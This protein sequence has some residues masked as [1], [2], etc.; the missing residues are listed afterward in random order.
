MMQERSAYAGLLSRRDFFVATAVA[1][2]AGPAYAWSDAPLRMA[3]VGCGRHGSRCIEAMQR[4]AVRPWA[5]PVLACDPAPGARQHARRLG[6]PAVEQEAQAAWH[7]TDVDAVLIATPDAAH[8]DIAAAAL[9]AGKHVYCEAPLARDTVQLDALT[10]AALGGRARL[11]AP[12]PA[13]A[14]PTWQRAQQWLRAG[15]LGRVYYVQVDA[16]VPRSG[17]RAPW[18]RAFATCAGV[19][20]DPLHGMLASAMAMRGLDVPA[21]ADMLGGRACRPAQAPPESA[22]VVM[23]FDGGMRV[24][25]RAQPAMTP[26]VCLRGTK[27]SVTLHPGHMEFTPADGP[28][29]M[30]TGLARDPQGTLADGLRRLQQPGWKATRLALHTQALL[31]RLAEGPLTVAGQAA[32]GA[33]LRSA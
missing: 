6:V 13:L 31:L 12:A 11:W 8:G 5:T 3:V 25:L 18:Q 33:V 22:M 16:P 23:E 26:R 7:S 24:T 4:P 28:A 14:D 21:Q 19:L 10:D 15:R 29:Q 32:A 17:D 20:G 27:G 1:A 2:A 30:Y 9:R